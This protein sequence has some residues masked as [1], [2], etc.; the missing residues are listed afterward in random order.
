M[1]SCIGGVHGGVPIVPIVME[2]QTI[3]SF[4]Q[5]ER[6]NVENELIMNAKKMLGM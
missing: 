5:A 4:A 1:D 3:G 6:M 2:K